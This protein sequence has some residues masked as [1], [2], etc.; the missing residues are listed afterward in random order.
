MSVNISDID[1]R[2]VI[3]YSLDPLIIHTDYKILYIN[4]AA[5]KFFRAN[6]EEVIGASPLDIFK[7]TSKDAI[8]KRIQ[9][10]YGRPA[11]IIQETIY[12][13]DGSSVDVELYCHPVLVGNKKAIQTY[14]RD[15]TERKEAE[16]K[17]KELM[18]QI[19]EL[20]AT[21]VPIL[22]GIAVLPLV[23]SINEERAMQILEI[24]P[25]KVQSQN[26][27]CLIIDFSGIFTL[28]NMVADYLFK[29]NSVLSLLGVRS[30][31]T[32]LRPE[33]AIL[34]TNLGINLSSIPTMS[35]VKDAVSYLGVQLK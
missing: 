9:S 29:I 17:Q 26:V 10:A 15:I 16:Q 11:D 18:I 20:S 27:D 31:I 8:R 24:V 33:L 23:G 1:Y 28:N 13:M 19:N 6:K 4:Q 22:S 35:T 7:E 21:V 12:R 3:E 32:G 30:I 5:E 25:E 34:A 14:V 2:E